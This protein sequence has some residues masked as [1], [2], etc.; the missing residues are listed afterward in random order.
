VPYSFV[1][2]HGVRSTQVSFCY[3]T[4][5]SKDVRILLF[6]CMELYHS[7]SVLLLNPTTPLVDWP[8]LLRNTPNGTQLLNMSI[9]GENKA[10]WH[11]AYCHSA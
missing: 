10:S 11:S 1:I 3:P 6:G 5:L 7:L 2:L 8:F 4:V 9:L